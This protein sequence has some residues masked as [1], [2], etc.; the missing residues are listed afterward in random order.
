M[1]PPFEIVGMVHLGDLNPSATGS[2]IEAVEEAAIADALTLKRAGFDGVMIEN[3]GD[4][5]FYPDQVPAHT[6]ASMSRIAHSI[7][8]AL[9]QDNA[10]PALGINVLRNDAQ[11]ALAIAAAVGASFVRVNVLMGAM[12]TDQGIIEGKAHE[13]IR[14]R[15]L[16]AP[17]CKV[18]ADLR[19]KHAAPLA[20]RPL[21]DEAHD[22]WSRSG[23]DAIIVSGSRT[24]APLDL[25]ELEI[26]RDA[27]PDARI[28]AGSG[29][30]PNQLDLLIPRLDGIIVGTW[31]KSEGKSSKPVDLKRASDF[32]EA[33][34][35]H[36]N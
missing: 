21:A 22:L 13:V 26:I 36:L 34:R 18:W 27:V 30:T 19:V 33:V 32:V 14:A 16:L 15:N 17:Q 10:A 2:P 28:I 3:F 4:A 9:N 24:G 11:G 31:I 12:V 7:S 35:E 20:E 8:L 25:K 6:I 23:A 1:T 29:V 5:P